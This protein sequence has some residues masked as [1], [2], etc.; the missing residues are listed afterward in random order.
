GFMDRIK[1]NSTYTQI[2][3]PEGVS[4]KTKDGEVQISQ[5]NVSS[6]YL[7]QSFTLIRSATGFV[8]SNGFEDFRG[9]I[10]QAHKFR[11]VDGQIHIKVNELPLNEHPINIVKQSLAATTSAINNSMFVVEKG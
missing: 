5:F 3:Q 11:G 10:G 9:Q 7:N 2:N 8:L 4:L 6:D 1:S